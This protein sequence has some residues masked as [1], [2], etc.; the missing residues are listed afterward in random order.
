MNATCELAGGDL[1]KTELEMVSKLTEFLSLEGYRVRQEVPNMGQSADLVATRGRWVTFIEAKLKDW[2]RA[3]QQCRTHE[4]VADFICVAVA[5]VSVSDSLVQQ[6]QERGYGII[7]RDKTSG[8]FRW[9]TRPAVNGR[10]WPPQ[11]QRLRKSMRGIQ[12]AR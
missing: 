11:R 3:I 1:V 6:A 9:V 7:H 12:Y 4:Q 5:S 8:A 2:K 10:V